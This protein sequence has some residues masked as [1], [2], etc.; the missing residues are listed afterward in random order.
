ME[1]TLSPSQE[2][3]WARAPPRCPRQA[4]DYGHTC[5]IDRG[6]RHRCQKGKPSAHAQ[7]SLC[8]YF[9]ERLNSGQVQIGAS[10]EQ[11]ARR[12]L[13]WWQSL[14]RPIREGRRA[15]QASPL[16]RVWWLKNTV[17]HSSL[18]L[19]QEQCCSADRMWFGRKLPPSAC[20]IGGG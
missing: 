8:G 6:R 10:T 2:A 5:E 15:N 17:K 13:K 9:Y 16:G 4:A 20:S 7:K 14:V 1:C 12:S 11:A 18:I 19:F 3:A